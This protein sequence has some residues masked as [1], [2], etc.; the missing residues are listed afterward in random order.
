MPTQRTAGSNA[1]RADDLVLEV[2]ARNVGVRLDQFLCRVLKGSSR[3]AVLRGIE[4]DRVRTLDGLPKK[5]G[6]RVQLGERYSIQSRPRPREPD[7]EIKYRI[8]LE[9]DAIVAVDK[10]AGLPVHPS[11]SYRERTLLT[12]LKAERSGFL[13]PAHR[14]DRETSGVV[15]FAKSAPWFTLLMKQFQHRTTKKQYLAI[16][17]GSPQA[18]CGVVDLPLRLVT[19]G[20]TV[21][22][23]MV[24]VDRDMGQTALTRWNVIQRCAEY[25]LLEVHPQTGRQHQI[26]AHLA[27]IGHPIVG[28]KI[29]RDPAI[30]A[31]FSAGETT[32]EMIASLV[33]ERHALHANWLEFVHPQTEETMRIEAP[34]P[35]DM[36]SLL[37]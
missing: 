6:H 35:D 11:P 3:T 9:D 30:F 17:H 10:G 13:A 7:V 18:D 36:R 14:L 21:L 12:V 1:A 33:L 4:D 32:P 20:E 22:R 31:A 15:I 25:T 29:Y 37:A 5:A 23:C 28:D 16:V 19:P 2:D 24:V 27:A 26:R 8:I 34:L